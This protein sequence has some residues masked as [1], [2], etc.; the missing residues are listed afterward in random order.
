[1]LTIHINRDPVGLVNY[2]TNSLAKDDYFF[3]GSNI[4]GLWYGKLKKE[5]GLPDVVRKNEFSAL[6]NNRHPITGEKLTVRDAAGRRTSIEYTFSAP[7]SVSIALSIRKDNDILT[8]HRQAV[9]TAMLHIENDMCTQVNS[10]SGKQYHQTSNIIFAQF[11]HFNSRPYEDEKTHRFVSDPQLHSHCVVFNCTRHNSRFQ[12]I[13]ASPIHRAAEYYQNIYRSA[14]AYNLEKLSYPIIRTKNAFEIATIPLEIRAKFSNRSRQIEELAKKL[15]ITNAKQKGELGAKSRLHKSHLKESENLYNYWLSCLTIK[16][17]NQIFN[18]RNSSLKMSNHHTPF[19]A[20]Q[21][22]I[23][24]YFSRRSAVM[25]KKVLAKALSL[26]Y[27][28]AQIEDVTEALKKR[29]DILYARKTHT[30]FLTIHRAVKDERIMLDFVQASQGNHRPINSHYKIQ[31]DFLN[32]DQKKAIHHILKS[33]SRISIL[34]GGAGTGKTTLLLELQKAALSAGLRIWA[35]APSANASRDV[36]RNSGFKNAETIAMLLN[37]EDLQDNVKDNIILIDEAGMVGVKTMN[38][39]FAIAKKQNARIILSGDDRQHNSVE[40]GDA[41][42]LIQEKANLPVAQVNEILRQKSE[43]YKQVVSSLSCGNI[44]SGFKQL[45]AMN[46]IHEISDLETRYKELAQDYLRSTLLNRTALVISPTHAEG[47][48]VTRFI[49]DRLKEEGLLGSEEKTI[50]ILKD[51]RFTV[52][53][54]KDV[55]LYETGMAIVFHRNSNCGFKRTEKYLVKGKNTDGHVLIQNASN[56][57]LKILPFE[58]AEN[59]TVH[60][61]GTIPVSQ[62]DIIRIT[63]NAQT[64]NG[65]KIYNGQVHKI[66]GFTASGQI[67]LDNGQVL[68]QNF[69]HLNLGYCL[70]SNAA[71]GKS[72]QDVFIASSSLSFPASNMK[73]FYVSISR[74]KETIKIYTDDK[75]ALLEAICRSGDRISALEIFNRSSLSIKEKTLSAKPPPLILSI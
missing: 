71:Q 14:L 19:S 11:E 68:K 6:A 45:E 5:L 36:L 64:I 53:E 3:E 66:E 39:I 41:L 20:L 1:M 8:A 32:A 23:D 38:K 75:E 40:A 67:K 25:V 50:S 47:E 46:A 17:R 54:K 58:E 13:E 21:N 44:V 72:C 49:R 26:S 31:R 65:S 56:L 7:K 42:R 4:D 74:G 16:E 22:A 29:T 30:D 12:A 52:A 15:N 70:S 73:Q 33:D 59:F 62:G 2:F 18:A 24:H 28:T 10:A 61:S 51:M 27:G 55:A 9:Q 43:S 69:E 48:I 60:Y 63:S 35:F 34:S 57:E 37:S